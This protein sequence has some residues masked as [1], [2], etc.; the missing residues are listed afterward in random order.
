[1]TNSRGHITIFWNT[2]AG[3]DAGE[4][5]A[6]D[7]KDVLSSVDPAV[8]FELIGK[9]DD[10]AEKCQSCVESGSDVLVAAG[11]DGT[12]NAI[13]SSA[14][15]ADK[16]LGVIPAGT[17]NHFAR[18]LEISLEPRVAAEQLRDGHEIQI[19]VGSVNGRIFINNSVLGLYPVYRTARKGIESTGL[20]G[21]RLGRFIS[22]VGGILKVFWRLP[23]ITLRLTT[24]QGTVKQIK[25]PFVLVANNEH[26]LEDW[27]VGHR[28]SIDRGFLW[29]Y[30]MRKTS[31]WAVLKFLASFLLKRF[32][33]HD[34]FDIY[35]V[36]EFKI[37]SKREKISVGVDGE[38]IRMR[39]PLEYCSR[40]KALRVIAPK[41]YLPEA[42]AVRE[43]STRES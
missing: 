20:G 42:S 21:T 6:E 39:T 26:D 32:S 17:L 18:D 8:N 25:T 40:P 33:R 2:G 15:E 24:D 12:I 38:V 16:V 37:E 23:H 14:V 29:V 22:V 5:A 13:A 11:G 41:T 1:M 30:V 31:R 43:L 28:T 34:A 3:W 4:K 35:Q 10:F 36:K 7:V 9:G 19:D 27:R